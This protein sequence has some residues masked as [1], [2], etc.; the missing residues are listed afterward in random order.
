VEV[1]VCMSVSLCTSGNSQYV[2]DFKNGD[3]TGGT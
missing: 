3:R 1:L 2:S